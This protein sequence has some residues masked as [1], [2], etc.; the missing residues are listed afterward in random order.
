MI[1]DN[2][3]VENMGKEENVGIFIIFPNGF[4]QTSMLGSL[5]L[6]IV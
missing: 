4:P 6:G 1:S 3:M 2:D 5:K